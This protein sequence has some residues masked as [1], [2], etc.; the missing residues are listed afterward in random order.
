MASREQSYALR[1]KRYARGLTSELDVRQ[2]QTE[3]A[4][5]RAQVPDLV[6]AITRTEGSLAVLTG[7][8]PR[9]LFAEGAARGGSVA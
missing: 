7:A 9:A 3:L 8:S 2:A 1:E 6:D 4:N 5:A